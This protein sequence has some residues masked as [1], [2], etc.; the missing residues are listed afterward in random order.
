MLQYRQYST[1][2]G[3]EGDP[4]SV[5]I[6][7][8]DMGLTTG[9]AGNIILSNGAQAKNIYWRTGGI[10]T[11]AANSV[12][13][14]NIFAWTQVN[15]MTGALATGRLFAVT[16]QVTA[17]SNVITFPV[18]TFL[19]ISGYARDGANNGIEGVAVAFSNGGA[20]VTTNASGYYITSVSSGWSG[21]SIATKNNWT[22]APV[23]YTY[24]GVTTNLVDQDFVGT[25]VQQAV[26]ISGYARDGGGNGL[27]GVSVAFS[28]GG[29][30][31]TTN[32]SGYYIASVPIGWSGTSIATKNNWTFTPVNYTYSGVTTNLV[33]QDFVAT[34][35]GVTI[36]GYV[37]DNVNIGLQGVSVAF[38]NGGQTVTTNASGYY[39]TSV[40]SGWSGTS[41]AIEDGR[42]FYP[43]SYTYTNVTTNLTDQN[44]I[45]RMLAIEYDL[46]ALP[47]DFTVLPAY[48]NPFNPTTTIRYGLDTDSY[49]T[50]DISDSGQLISTLQNEYQ[51]QGWHSVIW[52]GTNKYG[53]Q[54]PA[55]IYLSRITSNHEV[56]TSKLMLLK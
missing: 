19:N 53:E 3:E 47:I 39:I 1:L 27:Q 6:F 18:A 54:A 43:P 36:S 40:A 24:S 34:S 9:A 42:T 20:T 15:V 48:P 11:I 2:D 31:V 8:T 12:F 29:A 51:I 25:S 7:S 14:G 21:M 13:Y 16:E 44:F 45:R 56:K 26:T 28:N 17:Q 50:V 49:V 5:W 35:Q 23:N 38:S 52:N 10:T 22:F 30:T 46:T 33:D 4:N 41:T 37:K 32:T 55:G